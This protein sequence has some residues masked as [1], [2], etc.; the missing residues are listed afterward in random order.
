MSLP[1]PDDS[2]APAA[3][4]APA[5]IP[6]ARPLLAMTF[7]GVTALVFAAQLVLDAAVGDDW[8]IALGAKVN[9]LIYAG[10][11]WRLITPIFLHVGLLHAGLNL[12]SLYAIGPSV[13]GPFGHA[14]FAF[15]YVYSGATGVLLSLLFSPTPAMGAST[16]IFGLVG[17]LAVY[18]ARHQRA[19]GALARRQLTNIVTIVIINLAIGL[20][21]GI[22]NWGHV[23]GLAG[24]AAAAWLLGPGWVLQRDPI[25]SATR[26]ADR[27]TSG[28][29]VVS[30]LALVLAYLGL[31]IW[32]QTNH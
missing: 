6:H 5:R 17:A 11:Y 28:T 22:D 10:E 29:L 31:L 26:V 8:L 32:I 1:A 27:T 7:L 3:R 12:Y 20:S 23:G 19:F 18:L 9:P 24:G 14:R 25:T 16:A 13:E 30:A 15:I 2:V 21:P 4:P